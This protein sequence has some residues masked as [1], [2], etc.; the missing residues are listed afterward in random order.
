MPTGQTF[1]KLPNVLVSDQSASA[2]FEAEASD[3]SFSTGLSAMLRLKQRI[4]GC[5][6][7]AGCYVVMQH[8]AVL[9]KHVKQVLYELHEL[10]VDM[11]MYM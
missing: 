6:D 8:L 4:E 2:S 5:T 3:I 9:M 7:C 1:P 10:H 11:S